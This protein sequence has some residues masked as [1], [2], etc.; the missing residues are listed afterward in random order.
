MGNQGGMLVVSSSRVLKGQL[1]N[2]TSS[3]T[4]NKYRGAHGNL[5]LR[6]EL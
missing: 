1:L 3:K 6:I 4:R 5:S 2:S